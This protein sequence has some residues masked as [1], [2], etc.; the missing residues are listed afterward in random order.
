VL[1]NIVWLSAA[2][3]GGGDASPFSAVWRRAG[4]GRNSIPGIR[5]MTVRLGRC[6][7]T[8]CPQTMPPVVDRLYGLR[9]SAICHR[10]F[11]FC[12]VMKQWAAS[13][14]VVRISMLRSCA[15]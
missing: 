3:S 11:L 4:T 13:S 12:L 10:Y 7:P 2:A 8:R 9:V 1:K 5:D 14:S 6:L 15:L